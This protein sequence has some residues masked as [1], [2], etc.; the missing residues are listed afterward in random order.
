[1]GRCLVQIDNILPSP[2]PALPLFPVERPHFSDVDARQLKV[3][4]WYADA[5]ALWV[6]TR[7][8]LDHSHGTNDCEKP[9]MTLCPFVQ[10]VQFPDVHRCSAAKAANGC[11]PMTNA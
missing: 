4:F 3:E 6:S 9:V 1:M 5:L 10:L 2:L 7:P 8:T 11:T